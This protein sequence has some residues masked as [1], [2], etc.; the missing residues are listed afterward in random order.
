MMVMERAVGGPSV[1][2]ATKR[3]TQKDSNS[4]VDQSNALQPPSAKKSMTSAD[5]Q[6]VTE[7]L[8]ISF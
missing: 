7:F 1:K 6:E 3:A 5:T 4:A 2:T 8:H